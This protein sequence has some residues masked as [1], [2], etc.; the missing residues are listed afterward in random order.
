MT[1]KKESWFEKYFPKKKETETD[2]KNPTKKWSWSSR[3]DDDYDDED[4]Y[5]SWWGSWREGYGKKE[6]GKSTSSTWASRF[7]YSYYYSSSS[8]VDFEEI[9]R[10]VRRSANVVCNTD[11][12][13]GQEQNLRVEWANENGSI[14]RSSDNTVFLSPSIFQAGK[15]LKTSWK[16]D[17]KT[18]VLIAETLLEA[19]FK[20]TIDAKVEDLMI[21]K[22]KSDRVDDAMKHAI[23][24]VLERM[25]AE[26]VVTKDY[27]GFKGYFAAHR[28]YHTDEDARKNLEDA[29]NDE[30]CAMTGFQS[31]MWA[32]LHP[33]DPLKM[34]EETREFVEQA[35]F[36]F[37]SATDSKTRKAVA[38][39][40][41]KRLEAL[42]GIDSSDEI[43]DM[44]S[45][46]M[47]SP[48]GAEALG[49]GASPGAEVLKNELGKS[50]NGIPSLFRGQELAGL[51]DKNADGK[52]PSSSTGMPE[53]FTE[54][55]GTVKTVKIP[56]SPGEYRSYVTKLKPEIRALKGRLKLRNE[57]HAH[58][59]RGLRRGVL[60]E[61]SLHKLGF[62]KLGYDDPTL[63]EKKE[64][65]S[66]PNV[67]IGLLVDES[68]SMMFGDRKS[69]TRHIDRARDTAIVIAEALKSI[70]GADFCVFGHTGQGR[71]FNGYDGGMVIHQY[72]TPDNPHIESIAQM[73]AYSENLDGFAMAYAAKKMMEWFVNSDVRL[74]IHVTD[75]YPAARDYGGQPAMKHMGRVGDWARSRGVNILG[76]GLDNAFRPVDGDTMYGRG[77]YIV[78]KH[79]N[80][81]IPVSNFLSRVIKGTKVTEK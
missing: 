2:E 19:T 43:K 8:T 69:G 81:A 15:C 5:D 77:R 65:I 49:M 23:W 78:L 37:R 70:E 75:G 10:S 67:A 56:P 26:G 73:Q 46:F 11:D 60:D 25:N 40:I 20:R 51:A 13:D 4:E 76:I 9:L 44:L 55:Q 27:P 6:E 31:V 36:D 61:G 79:N 28:S 64:I 17:E 24:Y 18:D 63:F 12:D 34:P 74:L 33:D 1:E 72:Y 22:L 30:E 68:G 80:I 59:E 62:H 50:P 47:G 45:Q 35:C 29:L 38:E 39:K 32:L 52:V 16:Q 42:W 58:Y 66:K 54:Y 57:E 48:K 53:A 21:K 7:S 14:N 71:C 41:V 3:K